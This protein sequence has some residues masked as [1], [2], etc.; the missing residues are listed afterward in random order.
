MGEV[1]LYDPRA[2]CVFMREYPLQDSVGSYR[3]CV[4][5]FESNL[6]KVTGC[7]RGASLIG[8]PPPWD[9]AVA[10]CPGTY[11]DPRGVGVSY[12]RSTPVEPSRLVPPLLLA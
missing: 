8:T 10:L 11:G 2:V 4:S 12:K 5:L 3:R 7:Y 1:P 9:P 6:C